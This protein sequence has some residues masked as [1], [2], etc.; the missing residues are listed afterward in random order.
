MTKPLAFIERFPRYDLGKGIV[1]ILIG[2]GGQGRERLKFADHLEPAADRHTRLG[3][4]PLDGK[5]QLRAPQHKK[6]D[7]RE[8]LIAPRIQPVDQTGELS[9]PPGGRQTGA[10]EGQA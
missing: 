1:W 10:V 9:D 7:R 5:R 2:I 6:G 4:P 8:E 3:A